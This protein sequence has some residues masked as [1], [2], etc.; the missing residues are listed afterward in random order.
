MIPIRAI[1]DTKHIDPYDW[2]HEAKLELP[3][4]AGVTDMC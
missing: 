1:L 4:T 3:G 2:T